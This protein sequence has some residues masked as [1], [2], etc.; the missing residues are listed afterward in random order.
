[1]RPLKLIVS[2]FGPYADKTEIDFELLG[3]QGLYLITGDTGSGK[4]TIFDAI[5]FALYG[6]ASGNVRE[7]GMFRSLYADPSTPTYVDLTFSYND[8]IYRIKRSPEYLRPKERGE[9]MTLNKAE[10]EMTFYDGHMPITKLAD[11]TKAVEELTGLD[12]KQFTQIALIAQGDFS[13][14]IL[15][16]TRER[17]EIFRQIFQTGIYQDIEDKL[18][19]ETSRCRKRYDE[20]LMSIS[21][22]MSGVNASKDPDISA[23]LDELKK[24][25]YRGK[26]ERALE[27]LKELLKRDKARLSDLDEEL[28]TLDDGI[29]AMDEMLGKYRQGRQTRLNLE[30]DQKEYDEILPKFNEARAHYEK[31]EKAAEDCD[32]LTEEINLLNQKLEHCKNAA[33]LKLKLDK[34]QKD[35]VDS[36]GRRDAVREEYRLMETSFLDAQA[37]MLAR[38]LEDG[39]PCPVCGSLEHP[40]PAAMPQKAPEKSQLDRKK[41]EVQAAENESQRLS[42]D[43]GHLNEQLLKEEGPLQ[44]Q[45]Q[46]ELKAS[47]E[48]KQQLKRKLEKDKADALA[49]YQNYNTREASLRSA[50]EA[51]KNQLVET[52]ELDEE[53]LQKDRDARQ[54]QKNDVLRERTDLYAAIKTNQGICDAVSGR[55]RELADAEEMYTWMKALSDTAGG[56]L[57]GKEKIELETYV[58]MAYFDRILRRANLRFL[59]MTNGQYEFK[60]RENGSGK[61]EKAGLELDVIDHYNGTERSVKTLS[62]GESFQASLSLA[63]G[64]SDEVQSSSGGIRLDAMFVD[65]GF[66]TLDEDVLDKVI[67]TLNGL[68][69]GNRLVGVISH[70]PELK[71]RIEKKIV[72]TKEHGQDGI[73]SRVKIIV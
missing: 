47:L 57:S 10:A 71:D 29:R 23:E 20:A 9:G 42:S 22:Y 53:K 1:M 11:V 33:Q 65:E 68:T 27:I 70:V 37:G 49:V 4:T 3:E 35:Y 12:Y 32:A 13:K 61:K 64:L 6:E 21:Q 31:A 72:V 67:S 55:Q 38:E 44:G 56:T 18:K 50:I 59:T 2:A 36:C 41:K 17:S 28:K 24:E 58:Q 46:D 19:E 73:G 48:E 25:D 45:D 16:G 5:T 34:V 26:A 62:G 14:L 7:S 15:A 8:R 54:A 66:G 51:L 43:A 63:L 60:R 39:C 52:E 40:R 69:E 30:K